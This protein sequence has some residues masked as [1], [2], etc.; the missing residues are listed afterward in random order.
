MTNEE[1]DRQEFEEHWKKNEKGPIGY[2]PLALLNGLKGIGERY[3][4][5]SRKS[6]REEND[7]LFESA[8][9][10]AVKAGAAQ[11]KVEKLREENEKLTK[12]EEEI[13]EEQ[14]E[15]DCP[16]HGKLNGKDEC[17]RC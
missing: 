4:L 7:R 11:A 1:K 8:N 6:L 14:E 9:L 3:W 16:I 12:I 10:W 15:Y 5:A 13:M 17:P 2:V